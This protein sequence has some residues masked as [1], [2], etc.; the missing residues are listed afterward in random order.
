MGVVHRALDRELNRTVA[1]KVLRP[2]LVPDLSSLLRLKRELVLASRIS[3]EHVVRVYDLGEVKGRPLIAMELVEGESLAQVLNRVHSLPPSQTFTFAVQICQALRAI[4][5]ANIVHRDLKPG[6][7]LIRS[8]GKILVSDFGLAR[9]TLPRDFNLSGGGVICGTPRYVAPEQLSGLPAD[10]RSDL[11]ALGIVV[12]E[13][14]TGTTALEALAS[15]RAQ[16]LESQNENNNRPEELR[17]LAALDFVIR[18]CVRLDRTERCANADAALQ[19]LQMADAVF[20]TIRSQEVAQR[21]RLLQL[22]IRGGL[23]SGLVLILVLLAVSY[24]SVLRPDAAGRTAEGEQMYTK[25]ISLLANHPGD[26]ELRS[27]LE[28]L[29]QVIARNPNHM[30]AV[31]AR[32]R[33]LIQLYEVGQDPQWLSRARDALASRGANGL[34]PQERELF[35]A[36]ID[37]NRGSFQDVIATLQKESD[38]LASSK[39]ANLL[40]GRAFAASQG[41]QQALPYYR[42]AIRLSPE[43]WRSHNDLGNALLQLGRFE[44]ARGEF[45]RVIQLQPESPTG[46]SNSGLALLS[47]GDLAGARLKFEGALEL[48]PSPES[49]YNL[50]VTA[51]YSRD[52]AT[53]IPFFE[54]AT[55][56]RP[57]SGRYFLALADVQRLLHRSEPAR[58]TYG[59]ALSLL[60]KLAQARPLS[61]SEQSF[62]V[63]CFA[64]IGDRSSAWLALNAVPASSRDPDI[65]YARAVVA[66]LNGAAAAAGRSIADAV[67]YGYPAALIYLDP[68]FD[69][70]SKPVYPK[71]R[72]P[73]DQQ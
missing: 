65:A 67:R 18:H 10:A 27:A 64:R 37:L 63:L 6:N 8:D 17:K 49:Y 3:H 35:E 2:E 5:E 47:M 70:L 57:T 50:G 11:Y 40:L 41:P 34:S 26:R 53:S 22:S 72:A 68:N 20:P 25:A 73:T 29:D 14:L 15:L 1:V 52:Y 7:L 62:R 43:S 59:Q 9:S 48:A 19:D 71:A 55:R 56:M 58:E 28:D 69:G 23:A 36:T 16:W 33:T 24:Y 42:A 30:P 51:Y 54:A 61:V 66:L 21:S 12:L 13:M 39:D 45:A 60:D 4:H 46:Y 31:R 44:E 38:L 32:L